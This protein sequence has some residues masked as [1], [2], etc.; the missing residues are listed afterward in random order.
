MTPADPA[1]PAEQVIDVLDVIDP[2]DEDD[3]GDAGAD[4]GMIDLNIDDD[5]AADPSPEL[6]RDISL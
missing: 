4:F 2:I 5:L 3:Y 1:L 6:E